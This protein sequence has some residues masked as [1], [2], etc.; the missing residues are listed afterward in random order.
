MRT[1]AILSRKGGSGKTLMCRSLSVGALMDGRKTVCIDADEQNSLTLWGKRRQ[2]PAPLILPMRNLTLQKV[3]ADGKDRGADLCLIDTPPHA[4]PLITLAAQLADNCIIVTGSGPEDIE[5][6]SATVQIAQQLKKR[7][8]IVLNRTQ[9][10]T[11]SLGLARTALTTFGVPICPVA[12]TQAVGHLYAAA[13]G[14]TAQE[15]EPGSKA[16]QELSQVYE[17]LKREDLI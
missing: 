14:M 2:A 15:R 9:P 6:V 17:W 1:V 16:A 12:I 3:I 13:E 10:R 7:V 11:G 5:Q 4:R 8:A